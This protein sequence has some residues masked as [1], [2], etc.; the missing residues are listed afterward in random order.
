ME[1]SCRSQ[2]LYK[3]GNSFGKLTSEDV[4][5]K[6]TQMSLGTWLLLPSNTSKY[7]TISWVAD[8]NG[9]KIFNTQVQDPTLIDSVT[10]QKNYFMLII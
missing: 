7:W 1:P 9:R 4:T 10:A 2:V 3:D 5:Q 8:L 6:L